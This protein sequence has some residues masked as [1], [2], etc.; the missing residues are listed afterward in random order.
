M[1]A[2]TASLCWTFLFVSFFMFVSADQKIITAESGQDVTLTCRAPNKNIKFVHWS[3]ADLESE[4][5]LVY[6]D[7]RVFTDH[8]HPSF[9]NRVDLKDRQMKD[10]DVSLILKRVT[11][12]DDGTY[13]CRVFMEET[14]S[15]KLISIISLSVV[16]PPGKAGGDTED[17]GKKDGS[18]GLIVGL[19][20]PAVL[21]VAVV[22]IL[23]YKKT[24][25]CG[26]VL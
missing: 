16:V 18:V 7:E 11:S 15:W 13:K 8:Q 26:S 14:D 6:R 22:G 20:V 10:G 19:T 21:L 9:K 5:V 4:Y 23:I 24:E 3:R 1:S 25:F 2:L 17:E 12:V